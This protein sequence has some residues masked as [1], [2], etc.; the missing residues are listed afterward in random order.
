MKKILFILTMLF[1]LVCTSVSAQTSGTTLWKIFVSGT[2][3]DVTFEIGYPK[4]DFIDV[5]Q[6]DNKFVWGN[7]NVYKV[8]NKKEK[9]D[10][11][12]S[13]TTYDFIDKYSQRGR[14][15]YKDN[16]NADWSTKHM[17]YIHY[18]GQE[19]GMYYLSNEPV[20]Q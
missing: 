17:F 12:M 18:E 11:F 5:T 15:I 13:Y 4:Q 6:Y 16:R 1:M 8:Y 14:L 2:C 9:H 20:K 3:K 10:G 19:M 7:D